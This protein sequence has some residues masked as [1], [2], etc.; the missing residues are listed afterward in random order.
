[1]VLKV[2]QGQIGGKDF[3]LASTDAG[4]AKWVQSLA[5]DLGVEASPLFSKRRLEWTAHRRHGHQR[6]GQGQGR[7]HLRRA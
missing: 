2:A 7:D 5:E 3:V 4:R 6:A 1:M